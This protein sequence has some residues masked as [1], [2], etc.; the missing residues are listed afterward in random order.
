MTMAMRHITS[1]W[2]AFCAAMALLSARRWLR[3][4]IRAEQAR[5]RYH[6]WLARAEGRSPRREA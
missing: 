4:Q 5:D 1:A 6:T 2:L 3:R